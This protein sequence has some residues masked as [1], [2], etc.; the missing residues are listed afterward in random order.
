MSWFCSC[1]CKNTGIA[2]I[3]VLTTLRRDVEHSQIS[4]NTPDFL[5]ALSASHELGLVERKSMTEQEE[6][7]SK[8]YNKGKLLV[9]DMDVTQLREHRETLSQIAFEAKATL[10]AADD[11]L[12]ERKAKSSVKSKEWLVT[13]T[14]SDLTTSDAINAVAIRKA[15]MSKMDKLRQDLLKSLDKETVDEMI[16]QLE[17][18]ATEKNLKTVTFTKPSVET[19]AVQVQIVKP[20]IENGESKPAFNPSSI[21]F[22]SK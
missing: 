20:V 3:C 6:L 7:Y 16:A 1:G 22:G 15:R 14:Q 12:R 19:S 5:M 18:K 21:T 17:R 4:E 9:A 13:P 10:A 2:N 11:E 8:F